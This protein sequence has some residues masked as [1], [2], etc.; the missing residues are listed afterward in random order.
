MSTVQI[1]RA[2]LPA[3][4]F[5][6]VTNS[7]MRGQLPVP[8][9][10]L[11]R[12][13]LG[14][15][16]SLPDGWALDRGQL[17]GSVV[18][19]RDAVSTA[20][21]DLEIAGYLARVRTAGEGGQW[22]WAWYVTDDPK[23]RPLTVQPS[24]GNQSMVAT[25]ENG[26]NPQVAPSPDSPATADQGITKKTDFE[27]T[28]ENTAAVAASKPVRYSEAFEAAWAAYGRKG[29]KRTAW[30]EWQRAIT[31][32][33]VETITAAIPAYLASKPD[34]KYRKDFERWLKGDVWESAAA[35]PVGEP[36]SGAMTLQDADAWLHARFLEA[37]A[38]AVSART[39]RPYR[40][41]DARTCPRGQDPEEYARTDRREW[42][43]RNRVGLRAVLMG[44]PFRNGTEVQA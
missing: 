42:I 40:D 6:I 8:V 17:D 24:T 9:R 25:S 32:A 36:A 44:Q 2:P 19:G 13:L 5:M 31:R 7:F 37:D 11:P 27:K 10:A 14:Y 18:E 41:P 3:D 43:K 38:A 29:A 26:A 35:Q 23:E 22:S 12:V 34:A 21:N 20:L 15:M 28:E 4:R 1:R 39:G 33:P 16:L 30:A